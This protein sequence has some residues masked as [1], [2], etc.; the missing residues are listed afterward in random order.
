MATKRPDIYLGDVAID[1]TDSEGAINF[2]AGQPVMDAGLGTAVTISLF[3]A[4]G[5][6]GNEPGEDIGSDVEAACQGRLNNATRQAVEQAAIDA[7]AWLID[8]GV[9]SAVSVVASIERADMLGL[10]VVVTEPD[11]VTTL[12]KRY[13]INWDAT[14]SYMEVA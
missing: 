14:R 3:T 5:W 7:L 13:R 10:K 2:K 12:T 11:K 6:W 9:A 1:M 4:R 8:Y